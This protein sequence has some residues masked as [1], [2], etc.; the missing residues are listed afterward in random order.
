ML[1]NEKKRE[2]LNLV[3]ASNRKL[4]VVRGSGAESVN[5]YEMKKLLCGF[6]KKSGKDF[7]TEAKFVS[8]GRADILVLDDFRVIEIVYTESEASLLEKNGKYPE[9]L[10][11]EVVKCY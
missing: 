4:N 6:L 9:G 3:K 7:V 10:K 8:G 2:C 5:H 1:L 11:I